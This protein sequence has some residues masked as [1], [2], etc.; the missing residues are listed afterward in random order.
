MMFNPIISSATFLLLTILVVLVV[1]FVGLSDNGFAM[2][3]EIFGMSKD[4]EFLSINPNTGQGTLIHDNSIGE[5]EALE[6]GASGELIGIGS[7]KRLYDI[8][9]NTGGIPSQLANLIFWPWVEG[10]TFDGSAYYAAAS[11][12]NDV[13]AERLL[14]L[15]A[16]NFGATD[17]GPFGIVNDVDALVASSDGKLYGFHIAGTERIVEIDKTTGVATSLHVI[18]E[19]VIAADYSEDG[20]L[21]GVTIPGSG[22]GPSTLVTIDLDTGNFD[23]VGPIGFDNVQGLAVRGTISEPSCGV[24]VLLSLLLVCRAQSRKRLKFFVLLICLAI[25]VRSGASAASFTPIGD[26]PG[27]S[28]SSLVSD[29]SADGMVV[30]GASSS[31]SFDRPGVSG[32]SSPFRWTIREGIS[33]LEDASGNSVIGYAAGV[34]SDGSVVA[35]TTS[36]G[37]IEAFHWTARDGFVALGDLPGGQ[38]HS[39]AAAVSDD[40]SV[41]VG[42]SQNQFPV[43]VGAFYWTEASGMVA[44]GDLPGG[45]NS[46]GGLGVS[47]NGEVVVGQSGSTTSEPNLEAFYWSASQGMVGIGDFPDGLFSSDARGASFDGSVIVGSGSSDPNG[48]GRDAFRWT[49]E[50]GLVSLGELPGGSIG[51]Y[52]EDVSDDGLVIV[53]HAGDGVRRHAMYWTPDTGMQRVQGTLEELGVD[54]SGWEL[55]A[56]TSVSADG[57]IIAG[58]GYNPQGNI[59][60]WVATLE[61]SNADF[62]K[63]GQVDGLDFLI[64]QRGIPNGSTHAEGDANG[65]TIVNGLD[66]AIW[67]EQYGVALPHQVSVVPEP[68]TVTLCIFLSIFLGTSR[69]RF[70]R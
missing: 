61:P 35:G 29:I 64:W 41:V 30:V 62:N 23:T 39:Q 21:Y 24:L 15:D 32:L 38:F 70:T 44:V 14:R 31:D 13:R 7:Q 27:G 12:N 55:Y 53:G 34:S 49:A 59:E 52:A 43:G 16:T 63:D 48:S 47:G 57:R 42:H 54:M 69:R 50:T 22:G 37:Q 3:L 19:T 2:P 56:A 26:L 10:L 36:D 66:L 45:K 58:N 8:D 33:F 18:D 46:S 17:V 11:S 60:G 25:T 5:W 6:F 40:G 1:N 20:T 68:S 4:G 51:E 65:D 67:T 28:F 9:P